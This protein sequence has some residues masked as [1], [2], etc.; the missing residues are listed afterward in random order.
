MSRYNHR[1]EAPGSM[2]AWC[3]MAACCALVLLAGGAQVAAAQDRAADFEALADALD[4]TETVAIMREEGLVYGDQIAGAMLPD[5]DTAGWQRQITQLYDVERMEQ[6]VLQGLERA[7]E[8]AD[9]APMLAFYRSETGQRAVTLELAARRAFLDPEAEDAARAAAVEAAAQKDGP[10]ADLLRLIRRLIEGG[11]LIERNVT[12]SLNADM[13]FWRGVMDAGGPGPAGD[14][15]DENELA[16]AVI[17]G[18]AETRRETEAWMTAF[19]LVA[20]GPLTPEQMDEYAAFFETRDG[21]IL[22][23]ALFDGFNGMYDQLA[24]IL[25]HAAGTWMNSAP[26]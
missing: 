17:A 10:Q 6:L 21:R 19:L 1:N 20:C 12:A 23:A 7:L 9:L 3:R 18:L 16:D 26:L 13:M 25:G 15:S 24:Y 8:G 14:Q 2:L 5:V 11:D 22:N 4:I